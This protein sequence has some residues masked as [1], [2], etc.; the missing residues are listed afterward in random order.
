MII[1]PETEKNPEIKL[2]SKELLFM[3]K[4]TTNFKALLIAFLFLATPLFLMNFLGI[5]LSNVFRLDQVKIGYV[6]TIVA[7]GTMLGVILAGIFID[8][9][10]KEKLA[11]M[12]YSLVF[13]SLIGLLVSKH[14]HFIIASL[15]LMAFGL[16]SGWTAYQTLLSE[17][18][19]SKRGIFMSLL[20]TTNA[21]AVTVF[22]LLGPVFY[23]IG[24]Y[25]LLIILSIIT[26]FTALVIFYNI[27][28]ED[29]IDSS[30]M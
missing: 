17:I 1:L 6:Y 11:K 29:I 19:P 28:F 26:N 30:Q 13:I 5:Y 16:D 18:E 22:S 14:L 2:E 15:G 25:K 7:S 20:Y 9:I 21:L 12:S 10:G 23:N 27:S 8:K 3:I 4:K 24:G